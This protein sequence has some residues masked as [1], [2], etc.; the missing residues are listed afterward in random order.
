MFTLAKMN[1]LKY[2]TLSDAV[3]AKLLFAPWFA[4][5]NNTISV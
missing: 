2:S 3:K 5:L 4:G 1:L